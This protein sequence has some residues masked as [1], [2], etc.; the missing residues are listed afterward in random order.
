M[1]LIAWVV[2]SFQSKLTYLKPMLVS[3]IIGHSANV[4]GDNFY[5]F[6]G[7]NGEERF[8]KFWKIRNVNS[9]R[10]SVLTG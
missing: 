4:I 5:I 9:I 3:Q 6:G 10:T 7:Y 1:P 8:N 2:W